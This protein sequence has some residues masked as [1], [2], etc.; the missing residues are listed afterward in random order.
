MRKS[1]HPGGG[2]FAERNLFC[3]FLSRF[4]ILEEIFRVQIVCL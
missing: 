1:P 2:C 3:A 4:K